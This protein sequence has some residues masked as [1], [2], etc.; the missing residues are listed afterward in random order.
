MSRTLSRLRPQ[1]ARRVLIPVSGAL[2]ILLGVTT[3]TANADIINPT[4]GMHVVRPWGDCRFDVGFV[5]DSHTPWAA[6]G[7]TTAACSRRRNI[8][9]VVRLKFNG[10]A[11]AES[12]N[13]NWTTFSNAYGFGVDSSGSPRVLETP[14]MCGDGYW[15]TVTILS[16]SGLG[17]TSIT[18]G[19]PDYVKTA[20]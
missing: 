1:V 6:I 15:Q 9:A 4:P 5:P 7:G 19:S 20:C 12:N 2:A 17:T 11:V 13:G 16:V 8:S 14:R 18:S 10:T 3:T